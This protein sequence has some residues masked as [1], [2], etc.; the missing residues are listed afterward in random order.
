[1]TK[2]PILTVI[3]GT[4]DGTSTKETILKYTKFHSYKIGCYLQLCSQ[5]VQFLE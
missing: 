2:M 5:T 4:Q 3:G 1:M